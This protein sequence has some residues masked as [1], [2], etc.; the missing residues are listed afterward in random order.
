MIDLSLCNSFADTIAGIEIDKA[1]RFE[2]DRGLVDRIL[3]LNKDDHFCPTKI[4]V[5]HGNKG[6][7]RAL[8][9]QQVNPQKKRVTCVAG[10]LW[11]VLVDLRKGSSTFGKWHGFEMNPQN[12][13]VLIVP[14]GCAIGCYSIT[15]TI[16]INMNEES[17]E[18]V[19]DMS[20]FWK[21][22]D[23]TISWPKQSE[24]TAIVTERAK[25]FMSF[26]EYVEKYGGI[27]V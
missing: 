4:V 2:D 24:T 14:P 22:P 18:I 21:D 23:L 20:I 16:S 12:H 26:S 15:N 9:F 7:V 13:C 27:E 1:S 25:N 6:A 8:N 10:Q 19:E 11:V 17:S 3:V 5:S